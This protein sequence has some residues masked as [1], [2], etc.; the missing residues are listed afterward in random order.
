MLLIY[1]GLA[2]SA[3]IIA[4]RHFADI[5][6]SAWVVM[7]LPLG[8]AWLLLNLRDVKRQRMWVGLLLAF[9]LGALR[10]SI[11]PT[12]SD[13]AAYNNLGGVTLTGEVID[14]PDLR[15]DRVQFRIAANS[16]TREGQT[17]PTSGLVLVRAGRYTDVR[18]G[19]R[20]TVTG[21]LVRPGVFDNFS[22]ADYL[23][24]QNVYSILRDAAVQVDARG[25]GNPLFAALI[26]LRSDAARII[27]LNLPEPQAALLTGILLGNERGISPD[28]S[29]AF[30]AAGAAHVVAISG[31]NMVII[32][33]LVMRLLNRL[34]PQPR[35]SITLGLAVI[36]LYTVFVGANAAVVRAALMSGV[37][38]IGQSMKRNPYVPT[39]LAFVALL[40]SLQNPTVL[41]DLSF[42]LSF[43]ATLGLA[44][45]TDPLTQRTER[46]LK[47]LLPA[48]SAQQ[49]V[50]LLSEPLIVTLATAITTTPLIAMHFG[51]LSLVMLPV[52]LLIVPV[53]SVILI[54][55]GL[56]LLTA[57]ILPLVGQVLFWMV[58]VPLTWTISVVQGFAALPFAQ[59]DV[60]ADPR[61][62]FIFFVVLIGWGIMHATKPNAWLRLSQ[63][64]HS[65][66]V[67]TSALFSSGAILVLMLAIGLT[68]PDGRLHVW[69]LDVGH[70][71]AVLIQVPGGGQV[72][73]DGGAYPSR[74]LTALGERI[75]FNDRELDLFF[76]TQ[77]DGFQLSA[78]PEVLARYHTALTVTNGQPS[79][80][81][82][83]A[84]VNAALAGRLLAPATTGTLL[85]IDNEVFFEVLNPPQVP[86]F[87]APLDDGTLLLRMRYGDVSFLFT[88]D[89]SRDAQVALLDSGLD[90]S[91][92]VMQL[93][94]HGTSRSLDA[95]FLDAVNPQQVVLQSDA[96]NLRGDPDAEIIAMVD[97]RMLYRTDLSGALHFWSDGR[98]LWVE[99]A[100]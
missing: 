80:N 14:A 4:A 28:V 49:A 68:R 83:V 79:Q 75:P 100:R 1:V 89:L 3:G 19:D 24:R 99:S 95:A 52:N 97:G 23:A 94:Q 63:W 59:V 61:F 50:G 15:D 33:G 10:M 57:V 98:A 69:F 84:E 43:F 42:Q 31:F 87:S 51:R 32:A 66:P 2:W 17:L 8:V 85:H 35:L 37:L 48:E 72:L 25:G 74:L 58:M 65:Q 30:N 96:A 78:L 88:G 60:S 44:L 36:A 92:Q 71:N 20:V 93:P 26:D 53:Q 11:V 29:D 9:S 12:T 90:L 38:V 82:I 70:Q 41:W 81:A 5:T 67:M 16:V 62:V 13:V 7:A 73:I 39:S 86:D 40:M 77:P 76:M 56:A 46:L 34:L 22:Y 47:A 27:A 6:L 91:A 18:Y 45:Y 64:V 21:R 55:G 54:V